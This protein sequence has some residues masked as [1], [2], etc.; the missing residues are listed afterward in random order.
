[1]QLNNKPLHEVEQPNVTFALLGRQ[2]E[3][4]ICRLLN[5]ACTMFISSAIY[6]C[7]LVLV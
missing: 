7:V 1:M 3:Q 4:F 2:K 6:I 5:D